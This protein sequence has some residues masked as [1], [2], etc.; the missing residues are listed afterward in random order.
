M[1][2]SQLLCLPIGP[3]EHGEHRGDAD[4]ENDGEHAVLERHHVSIFGIA[5]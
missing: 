2:T 3:E 4:G 5:W 1:L